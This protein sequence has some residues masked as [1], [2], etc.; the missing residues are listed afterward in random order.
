MSAHPVRTCVG[1]RKR[2]T[3]HDLLRVVAQPDGNGFT[4]VP[5]PDRRLPGRGAHLHPTVECLEL[6]LRRRSLGKALRAGPGIDTARLE[7]LVR[8][9]RSTAKK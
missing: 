5:D 6:A 4:A 3:P 8:S 1:C 2:T 7:E 9:A